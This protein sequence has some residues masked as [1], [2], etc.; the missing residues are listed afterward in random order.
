MLGIVKKYNNNDGIGYIIGYDDIIYLFRENVIIGDTKIEKNDI[1]D[2][3]IM[4]Y[5][6]EEL[7]ETVKVKKINKKN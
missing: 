1:V 5:N 6:K 4:I 2:F 7:P 3:E